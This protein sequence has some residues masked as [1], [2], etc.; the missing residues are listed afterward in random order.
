MQTATPIYAY[1]DPAAELLELGLELADLERPTW[2]EVSAGIPA[3]H[4]RLEDPP[5]DDD[6][7]DETEDDDDEDDEDKKD[8]KA[9]KG[10]KGKKDD[11]TDDRLTAAEKAA[12]AA[13]RELRKLK[14][15]REA[16]DRK[17]KEEA[18]KW[19][20]LYT[21]AK[22]ELDKL[23]AEAEEGK[24]RGYVESALRDLNAK[25]PDR[26]VRLVDLDDVEDKAS[27]TRAVARLKREDP[28]LFNDPKSR[29]KKG[30]GERDDEDDDDD[31]TARKD[32]VAKKRKRADWTAPVS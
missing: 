13:N 10:K 9:G 22:A 24:V 11:D 27:A 4:P 32:R 19:E 28:S 8:D 2:Q 29:Q 18:G 5:E 26:Y 14:S 31:D 20:D 25:H 15:E 12:A 6:T 23:K 16:A 3:W 17:A 7:E 1:S 30:A 21:E